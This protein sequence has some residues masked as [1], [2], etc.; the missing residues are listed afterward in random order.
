MGLNRLIWKLF[1]SYFFIAFVTAIAITAFSTNILKKNLVTISFKELSQKAEFIQEELKEKNNLRELTEAVDNVATRY[2]I[3]ITL[4]NQNAEVI[5][6]SH[7]ASGWIESDKA[8]E[9]EAALKGQK[10]EIQRFSTIYNQY[11][12]YHAEPFQTPVMTGVLRV[13]QSAEDQY[14]LIRRLYLGIFLGGVFL[15]GLVLLISYVS[16]RKIEKTLGDFRQSVQTFSEGKLKEK[17]EVQGALEF[18]ELSDE[19]N[20]MARK[21]DMR[22]CMVL[23]ERNQKNAI[24][25]NMGEGIITVDYNKKIT[26]I[27]EAAMK[28]VKSGIENQL[29]EPYQEIFKEEKLKQFIGKSLETKT[30]IQEILIF[31]EEV[32]IQ[33]HGTTLISKKKEVMG[34]LIVLSDI[35]HLK[36]LESMR[37]DFVANVSHELKTPMTIIGGF[38]E[39][40]LEGGVEDENQVKRF[41]Q[42]IAHHTERMG[43]IIEDL[44]TLS[45]L[46][47]K[48]DTGEIQLIKQ[49]IYPILASALELCQLKSKDQEI[50]YIFGC[51]EELE[52]IV[53]ADLLEEAILNLLDNAAKYSDSGKRIALTATIENEELKIK[54]SDEGCGIPEGSQT[55]I[56][57][58]FYRVDKG[59]SRKVGGTGLGLSIVKHIVSSHKGEIQ[60]E[61]EVG[62]GSTFTI[63]LPTNI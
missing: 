16:A 35:T 10:I 38:I 11:Y 62:K 61:S 30:K 33:A 24:L 57:E 22:H 58:R 29:G 48:E 47:R 53:N 14:K 55:R 42:K 26:G 25:A 19:M 3:R 43:N 1:P 50:H 28:F 2:K 17:V 46:E 60:L 18:E 31:G 40:L 41:L 63:T 36:R 8:H 4:L 44:L 51:S 12:A 37:K 45:G 34:A 54:I 27:N 20:K 23:E 52:G 15:F 7:V 49:P 39:T 9:V 56:F 5:W 6:D 21:L 59:R 32:F 13:S